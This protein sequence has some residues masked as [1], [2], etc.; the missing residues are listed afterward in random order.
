MIVTYFIDGMF[1][2]ATAHLLYMTAGGEGAG[3]GGG[4]GDK[5]GRCVCVRWCGFGQVFC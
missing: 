4:D 5:A 3:G 1:A 2:I